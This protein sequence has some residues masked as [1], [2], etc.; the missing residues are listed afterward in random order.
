MLCWFS[1]AWML[2]WYM[3]STIAVLMSVWSL[4]AVLMS[5]WSLNAVLMSKWSLNAVLMFMWSLNVLQTPLWSFTAILMSK[6]SLNGGLMSIWSMNPV[7][8]PMWKKA[9][10]LCWHMSDTWMLCW[11]REAWMLCWSIWSLN[12]VLI[13]TKLK[14]CADLYKSLKA[15]LMSPYVCESWVLLMETLQHLVSKWKT[16]WIMR[17]LMEMW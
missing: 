3:W 13:Y 4:N 10:V 9:W 17:L 1:G 7:E 16:A 11:C 5:K 2:C 6:W 14:C 12:V 8:R 15:V